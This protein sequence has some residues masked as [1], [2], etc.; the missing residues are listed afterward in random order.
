MNDDQSLRDFMAKYVRPYDPE[1]DDYDRPP[2]AADIKEGKNDPIYNAHSYHTKVP[3]R[4]IIPYIL[5]Y[6]KPGDLILDPFC[7][8][9]MTGVAA[10]MCANPPADLLEQ[11]LEL[12]DRVGPR[13]CILNDLSPAACHIAYNYNTP[14]DVDAL[15]REFERIKV[16][17]KD[18]FDWLYG[19]EHYEPAMGVYDPANADVANRL[20]NPPSSGSIHTLLGSEE[21][22]WELLTKA[23]VEARLGYPVTELPPDKDWSDL[24]VANVKQ[25]VCIPATIQYT[26]WS[27][28]YRCEGFV[29][30]EEPT[31]KVSTR[32]K[33]AG[34]LMMSKKR[35]ARGCS[36][37]FP[38]DLIGD[39]VYSAHAKRRQIKRHTSR[40]FGCDGVN[41]GS[42]R[43][44]VARVP[45]R[46]RTPVS[47]GSHL[48]RQSAPAPCW[49]W[50]A[51]D[52][53]EL[54]RQTF[55]PSGL[56]AD[57]PAARDARA[58]MR[59]AS[60]A[61]Q[62]LDAL[63]TARSA[64][65]LAGEGPGPG[66]RCTTGCDERIGLSR[67][68]QPGGGWHRTSPP[69]PPRRRHATGA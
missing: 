11:F 29:T 20:K 15:R 50:R 45:G 22:T 65:R 4:G 54:C 8:S 24:D 32:G 5:H 13:A 51:R 21:R 14:V 16:A 9:G 38:L 25:W 47:P 37:D 63:P 26:I 62:R 7:G 31:G 6:T 64:A 52:A 56:P 12:K 49:R 69:P 2:F 58:A 41:A 44:L 42:V 68:P 60:R 46:I 39:S 43:A 66:A 23:E 1:S 48:R 57:Q 55:V 28:V 33:N 36:N 3:P 35:V 67:C 53:A 30:I 59:V 61:G 19:T 27:D 34:K 17:V 40:I 10:Q 18:E